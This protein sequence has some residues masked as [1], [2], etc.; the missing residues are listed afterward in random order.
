MTRK[1]FHVTILQHLAQNPSTF[2]TKGSTFGT[3]IAVGPLFKRL[4]EALKVFKD[5]K[6]QIAL[7]ERS[8]VFEES[9]LPI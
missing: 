4:P 9:A 5:T 7:C 6:I 3:E 2:G 8:I 1:V